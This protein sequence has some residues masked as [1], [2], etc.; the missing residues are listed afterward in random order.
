[1]TGRD[2]VLP[3]DIAEEGAQP[4]PAYAAL[5]AGATRGVVV[6]H[7]ILGRQPEIDRV[8]DRFAARGYAAVAP[9]LFAHGPRLAC[10]VRLFRASMTGEGRPARDVERAR[11]WLCAEAGLAPSKVGLVGFCL[12]GGFVLA[13]GRGWPAISTNYGQLPPAALLKGLGPTIGCYGARDRIFGGL[14]PKLEAALRRDGTPVETHTYPSVGHSFLTD[15]RHP[16]AAALTS[17]F[18]HVRW[19]PEV[20]EDAWA[21]IM[22]FFDDH[23][24]PASPAS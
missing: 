4:L 15:G 7:E 1:M 24:S 6:L 2:V 23:L 5:P 11:R 18:F 13:I 8:V 21:H 16:V 17:P 3:P 12:T 10:V 20:A 9:D 22:R 19:D 14:A